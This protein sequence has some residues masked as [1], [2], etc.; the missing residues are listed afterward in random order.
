MSI[1]DGNIGLMRIA[2]V[3]VMDEPIGWN[4]LKMGELGNQKI[5]TGKDGKEK[6][7]G[8]AKAIFTKKGVEHTSFDLNGKDGAIALDLSKPVDKKWHGYFDMFT[9]YGTTEH[10]ENQYQ[11]WKNVHDMVRC[12]GA[13]VSSIPHLGYWKRHCPYHYSP[14]FPYIL[15]KANGYEVS[16]VEIQTRHKRNKLVNF[17]LI[18]GT[19]GFQSKESFGQGITFSKHYEQNTDNLF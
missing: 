5:L 2:L 14:E 4:G 10:V 1:S 13:I 12:G 16:Y 7:R 15:A 11:V 6:N 17:V 18:K 19:Q 9:N 8:P 3:D